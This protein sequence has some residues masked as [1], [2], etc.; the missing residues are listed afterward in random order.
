[1]LASNVRLRRNRFS[2]VFVVYLI[3][4]PLSL[5]RFFLSGFFTHDSP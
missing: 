5:F 2:D 1:M 3:G 4:T